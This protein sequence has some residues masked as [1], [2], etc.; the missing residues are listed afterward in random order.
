MFKSLLKASKIT[1]ENF[2]NYGDVID[3]SDNKYRTDF[4]GNLKNTL[5]ESKANLGIVNIKPSTFPLVFTKMEKHQFSSQAFIPINVSRYLIV[6]S[7]DLNEQPNINDIKAFLIPGDIG[8]NYH[9]GIWHCPLT[10]IDRNGKFALFM[11]QSSIY[12]NEIWAKIPN[13]TIIVD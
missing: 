1:Q 7:S 6:V 2:L 13:L 12:N 9:I 3:I 10:A 11:W 4:I 5:P 8:I